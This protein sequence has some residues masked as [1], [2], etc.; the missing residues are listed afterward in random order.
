[1]PASHDVPCHSM[2]RLFGDARW[3]W[4]SWRSPARTQAIDAGTDSMIEQNR[5]ASSQPSVD[6]A[7]STMARASSGVG[8]GEDHRAE[9]PLQE[10]LGDHRRARQRQRLLQQ[11]HRRRAV[12]LGDA[13]LGEP[14]QRVRLAG[15]RPEV[16]V[17][18]AGLGQLGGGEL[19]VARQQRRL[20]DQRRGERGG[21]QR[22]AAPGRRLQV[23]GR[24]R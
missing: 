24:R 20:A 19:E 21:T 1:M 23:A 9:D 13:D 22:A 7:R 10:M 15:R 2:R 17:Q 16:A 14:L 6:S 5:H 4:A 3:R 12:A 8:R 18:V 11:P